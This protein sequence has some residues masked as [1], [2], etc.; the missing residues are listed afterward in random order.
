MNDHAPAS[1]A[2]ADVP[3]R[4]DSANPRYR[5]DIDGLRAVAVLSVLFY[6]VGFSGFS[7]G[8]V[9]VDVF[10]VISGFLITRLIRDEV[11][12]GT[13]SYANF[14]ARRARRLFASFI[15]TVAASFIAGSLI[16]DRVYLQHFAGEVVYALVAAS[17]FFYWL[18]GGYFGVAEQ[19]KPL[20]HTW[21]LGVEEQFY[22]IWPLS[23]VLMLRYARRYLLLL[24]GLAAVAS[25]FVAEYAVALAKLRAAFLLL[26]GRIFEFAIGAMLVWLVSR[27]LHPRLLAALMVAGLVLIGVAV[28]H[29][30]TSTPFPT[31]YAL[32]P[33][34]GAALAIFGGT[35]SSVRW[36]LGNRL[37]VGIG[38]ISYSLYLVH[39]PVIVF[40]S[41]HRLEPLALHEQLLICAGSIL[42]AMLMYVYIEQPFR[43]PR[44]V[45]FSSRAAL[46][47]A[48]T[49][50]VT[51][52]LVPASIVWAKGRLLWSGSTATVSAA[53]FAQTAEQRKQDALDELL[54][55]RPFA[56]SGGRVRLM[57]VGDSHGG[58]IAAAMFLNL[59]DERYDYARSKFAPD[60]FS[61]T[62]RRPWILRV[63]GGQSPCESQVN[64][65]RRSRSL[66]EADYL[67]IADRWTEE[68]LKGFGQGLALLR[69]LTRARIVLVGQNATFPTFD[70]SLRY[71]SGAQLR[72]LNEVLYQQQSAADIRINAAL[73][74]LAAENGIGFIDRQSLV[75]SQAAARC[76]VVTADGNFLYSD[77]NH[78]SYAG[79]IV[80]G[81]GM[82]Q[83]FASIAASPAGVLSA[84]KP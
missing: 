61:S 18:D 34:L 47:F 22:L 10:F 49:V 46:G 56:N 17:N 33:C 9:G 40:Y 23:I 65:M 6:H 81:K 41:Y 24:L 37:M 63:T 57:F 77:T 67:F 38:K 12:A 5:P 58:D 48:C 70:D 43:D 2:A 54:R 20:L 60:C 27:R 21:S 15:F 75:C 53:Q 62:D 50:V 26:P 3:L 59:G 71:L 66:A 82:A 29:F 83:R 45:R 72:R 80:F 4:R 79:R 35:S 25:L 8:W 32:V 68:S 7:G 69:S 13:F 28:F 19:Y 36:L 76:E 51:I 1:T 64:E 52:L 55:D 84:A 73:R 16:F 74:Q 14:Y 39:W 44:R 11:E 78:W 42:A 31:V 30:T